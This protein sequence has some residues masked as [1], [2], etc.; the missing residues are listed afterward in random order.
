[1]TDKYKIT[2][3]TSLDET[4]I[5]QWKNLWKH[6]HNASVFNSYEW[7]LTC[8]QT[9]EFKDFQL[10]VCHEGETVKAILPLQHMKKYGIPVLSSIS[11]HFTVDT[12]FLMEQYDKDLMKAFFSFLFA[13][14]N[15]FLH[16][17][18]KEASELLHELFPELFFSIMSINPLV[19]LKGET[20]ATVSPST[21]SQIKK[22]HRKNPGEFAFVQ[23][24]AKDM[25][26]D[27]LGK[28]FTIEQNS[29]K[30]SKK[31]DIFSNDHTKQ[32]F[33]ALTKNLP[34]EVRI[35][36]LTY[37]KQPICYQFGFLD[38]GVFNAYQT[39]YLQDFSKLRPGKTMIYYLIESAQKEGAKV[40]D[41]GG[42]ISMY[43]MEFAQDY[44]IL[45]DIYSSKNPLH[46]S[47][48]K[49]INFA[50]RK[51]QEYRP[52]KYSRDHEFL[53]KTL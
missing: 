21:V 11:N 45:Y 51:N 3:T 17:V 6:A 33:I 4:L 46:M 29:S 19:D 32:F 48:W 49:M 9:G 31:M 15:I 12:P 53:F 5:S 52:I 8:K 14:G 13:K 27:D 23:Y 18:D 2:L 43:K 30:K 47:L 20:Y 1:M 37:D 39:A 36:F 38:H 44:R 41:L 28:M 22:V 26:N 25:T 7:F 42:G 34:N 24:I 50:R 35:G 10:L 40:I 16:K